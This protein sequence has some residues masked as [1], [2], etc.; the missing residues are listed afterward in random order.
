LNKI[1][2]FY[3]LSK[4]NRDGFALTQILILT[5]GLSITI[6][7]LI[8][9]AVNRLTLTRI[10]KQE[11]N[12]R[13]ASDSSITAIKGLLNNRK[14]TAFNYYW[15]SKTCSESID[16]EFCPKEN[17]LYTGQNSLIKN[18]SSLF[19][20]NETENWCSN[21]EED[22]YGRQVAPKCSSINNSSRISQPIEWESFNNIF[23]N[24][25]SNEISISNESD[26]EQFQAFSLKSSEF[27]GDDRTGG[28]TSFLVE[29]ISKNNPNSSIK[30]ATNKLR[31]NI[32]V[33]PEVSNSG[34]AFISA[35]ENDADKNSMF[36]GNI[37]VIGKKGTILWRRNILDRFDCQ[38]INQ[39]SGMNPFS[40]LPSDGGLWVQP[41]YTPPNPHQN[42]PKNFI[43]QLGNIY[44]VNSSINNN[45]NSERW[46]VNNKEENYFGIK[47]LVV[48]GKDSQLR[49]FTSD[50]QKMTL[51]IDGSID[52]NFGGKICHIDKNNFFRSCGSGKSSNLTLIF[53]P[54]DRMFNEK[55]KLQCSSKGGIS[56]SRNSLIPNNSFLLGNTGNDDSEV[57]TG[58]VYAP[59]ATFT[60]ASPKLDYYQKI[61][62]S[63][64]LLAINKGVYTYIQDTNSEKDPIYIKDPKGNLINY[65]SDFNDVIIEDFFTDLNIIAIGSRSIENQPSENTMLKMALVE[66]NKNYYLL[67]FI[68]ENGNALFVNENFNGR[69]WRIDLGSDPKKT[70]EKGNSW[71]SYYG[72]EIGR[73]NQFHSNL[74]IEGAMWAKNI[75]LDDKAVNWEFK[76]DFI[77]RFIIRYGQ[78]FNYGVP[79]YRGSSITTWDTMRDFSS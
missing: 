15:L 33:S 63:R 12:S 65:V 17:R 35:G 42:I 25:L 23:S 58:F 13:N 60:T 40:S 75:C 31:V 41:I 44:C 26:N 53:K 27:Y 7:A 54:E 18:M 39:I 48:K 77:N 30:V 68:I 78:D 62:E 55:Q 19:W 72:I 79:Y 34:F 2:Q 36:L 59:T 56:F 14:N 71:I 45:C 64:E 57:F 67:G 47:N 70:D 11:F 29:G 38:S 46:L 5:I 37:D 22:C 21:N 4:K 1:F 69:I 32:K 51:I 61:S 52:V 8:S 3:F 6:T 10:K 20:N 9:T 73:T 16:Q 28:T 50:S 43:N 49:I 74:N 66:K 24:L 76:E